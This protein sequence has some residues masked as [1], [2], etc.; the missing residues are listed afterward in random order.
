MT[1]LIV[2][3]VSLVS[4]ALASTAAAQVGD[5]VTGSGGHSGFGRFDTYQ[6]AIDAHSGPS[7]ESPTGT[8]S[9]SPAFFGPFAGPVTCLSVTGNT[10][11][12]NFVVV[13]P[14]NPFNRHVFTFSVTDSPAGDLIAQRFDV[15]ADTDCTPLPSSGDAVTLGDIV[16]VDAPA[17]PTSKAQCKSGGWRAYGVFKNQGDC[18]SFVATKGK[19]LP[20]GL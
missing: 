20:T 13:D 16:V 2:A 8:A 12:L 14:A 5:S 19:N 3:V 10:G 9:L 6:F 1:R 11:T 7:G 15:R 18:V 4:A 17:L